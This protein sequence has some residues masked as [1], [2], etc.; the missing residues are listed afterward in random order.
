M[1]T[2]LRAGFR[3]EDRLA[4]AATGVLGQ[5]GRAHALASVLDAVENT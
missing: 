3:D 5:G 1:T 2:V 4:G